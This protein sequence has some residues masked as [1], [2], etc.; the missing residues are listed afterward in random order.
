MESGADDFLRKNLDEGKVG[1]RIKAAI[2]KHQKE[3][4]KMGFVFQK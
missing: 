3:N 4:Q 1:Q 2:K